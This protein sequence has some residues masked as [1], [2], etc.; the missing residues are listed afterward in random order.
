MHFDNL[1]GVL[2]MRFQTLESSGGN[3]CRLGPEEIGRAKPRS[4]VFLGRGEAQCM[5][6]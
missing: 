1:L 2:M 5:A 3:S 6:G 4:A